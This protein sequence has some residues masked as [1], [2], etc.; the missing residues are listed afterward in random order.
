MLMKKV[1]LRR[2]RSIYMPVTGLDQ[3]FQRILSDG[4]RFGSVGQYEEIRGKLNFE[5]DP[6]NVANTRITD[7]AVS[8]THLTLP[9]ICCV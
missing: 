7:I 2:E 9:T 1:I 3:I 5:I 8:Y 6:S 4:K